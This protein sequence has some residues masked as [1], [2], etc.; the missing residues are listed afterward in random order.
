MSLFL[1]KTY[2]DHVKT[3]QYYR[4]WPIEQGNRDQAQYRLS[5]I[6]A[7]AGTN[8]EECRSLAAAL[9]KPPGSSLV[10]RARRCLFGRR[11]I[12]AC[13]AKWTRADEYLAEAEVR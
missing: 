9:E 4:L 7:L 8:S 13:S 6:C 2:P 5:R 1:A 3:W 10:Y 11:S 12:G